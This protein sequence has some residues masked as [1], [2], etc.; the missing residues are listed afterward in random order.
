MEYTFIRED[1]VVERKWASYR[2]YTYLELTRL[3]ED[4]G[5]TELTSF[6]SL[7][8]DPYETGKSLYMLAKR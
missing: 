6:S 4:A 1:R 8:G 2:V 7:A 3:L 5:F